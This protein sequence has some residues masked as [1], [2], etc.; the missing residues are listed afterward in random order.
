MTKPIL[1]FMV[2]FIIFLA[3]VWY[4]YQRTFNGYTY[5]DMAEETQ[6]IERGE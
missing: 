4:T 1:A 3:I 5:E 2:L 6:A